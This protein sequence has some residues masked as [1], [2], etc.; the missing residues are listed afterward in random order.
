MIG[1]IFDLRTLIA[2]ASRLVLMWDLVKPK[3]GV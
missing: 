2:E 3:P 1:A